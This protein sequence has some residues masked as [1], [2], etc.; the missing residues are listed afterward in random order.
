MSAKRRVI[1]WGTGF[2]GKMV[3]R[4]LAE[5]PAFEL[6]GVIVSDPEKHGRDA[7]EIAGM[8]PIGV[9][10]STDADAVLGR[11]ADA[12]AYFGPT[13][14]YA[15]QNIE[16]MSKAMRAGMDVV[17]TSMTPLVY[18]PACPSSMT[19]ALAKV[20]VRI[21]GWTDSDVIE[22]FTSLQ[23]A[24]RGSYAAAS[25]IVEALSFI[26]ATPAMRGTHVNLL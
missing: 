23:Q 6:V 16:N 20:G 7:G 17:S 9:K 13:A 22:T 11:G 19:D 24:V 10:A 3:I 8:G 21:Y 12:V 15:A 2:V 14:E 25:K 1:L 18:P 5:H 26:A 4:E